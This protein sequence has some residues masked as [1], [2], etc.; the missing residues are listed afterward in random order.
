MPLCMVVP[1]VWMVYFGLKLYTDSAPKLLCTAVVPHVPSN[2]LHH[3][4][5]RA[6]VFAPFE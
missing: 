6:A 2:S 4:G 3:K 5:D 1:V